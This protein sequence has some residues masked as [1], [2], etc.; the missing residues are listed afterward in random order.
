MQEKVRIKEASLLQQLSIHYGEITSVL[1]ISKDNFV[2]A[3][4]ALTI[5]NKKLFSCFRTELC[6]EECENQCKKVLLD[7][8]FIE[9]IVCDSISNHIPDFN[10]TEIQHK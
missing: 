6:S 10:T 8:N 9:F 7:S 1:S 5:V 3:K 2:V 4:R